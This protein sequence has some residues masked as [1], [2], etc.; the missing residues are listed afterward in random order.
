MSDT[1][2]SVDE[3]SSLRIGDVFKITNDDTPWFARGWFR[4]VGIMN[5]RV[6]LERVPDPE[7][8]A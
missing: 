4:V 6:D 5:G 8:P 1:W 3:S 2:I 7:K